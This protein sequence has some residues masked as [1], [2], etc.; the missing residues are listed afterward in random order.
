MRLALLGRLRGDGGNHAAIWGDV[1]VC[2]GGV[3]CA[4]AASVD[5]DERRGHASGQGHD[6][7]VRLRGGRGITI[8]HKGSLCDFSSKITCTSPQTRRSRTP[9]TAREGISCLEQLNIQLII[10]Y[11]FPQI[12]KEVSRPPEQ[13]TR[14][15][16][17]VARKDSLRPCTAAFPAPHHAFNIPPR[18]SPVA[19][20]RCQPAPPGSPRSRPKQR[21]ATQHA[22]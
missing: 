13:V 12:P 18:T 22:R 6:Y 8:T 3:A 21:P 14:V 4:R 7:G 2:E 5:G 16:N 9:G 15:T 10:I 11:Q 20:A 17:L 1:R 19:C